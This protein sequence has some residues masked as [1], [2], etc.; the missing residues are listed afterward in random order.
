M[1]WN[2]L[3]FTFFLLSVA[4]LGCQSKQVNASRP[5]T[6]LA[7][8]DSYTIGE[9]VVDSLRWPNQLVKALNQTQFQFEPAT[10]IAKT[11]WTTDELAAAMDKA[12]LLSRYDYVSLLIGVNNQ[13]RGRSVANFEEEF[14]QLLERAIDLSRGKNKNV[15]VVSIP[16]WGVMPFAQG[17]DR[18]KIAQEI[19]A[20]NEA[21][22][23]ICLNHQ[24]AFFDITPISR[25]AA[26]TPAL[27][28]SDGLHP[29]GAMYKRW[30]NHVLPFFNPSTNE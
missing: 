18:A 7:L 20:F 21:I 1:K 26:S 25:E 10:I 15:M 6:Y 4:L 5:M 2:L 16:D 24:V 23:Q 28:A 8:G 13:Y 29:S 12:A 22:A 30:V 17:R 9:S 27:V 11:G 3:Y 14:T 19:D